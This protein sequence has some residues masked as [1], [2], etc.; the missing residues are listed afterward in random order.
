VGALTP[1][2]APLTEAEQIELH[3]LLQ[4]EAAHRSRRAIDRFFPDTGP[5]RRALYQKHWEDAIDTVHVRHR[6]GGTSVLTFRTCESGREAFQ[7][8]TVHVV[9][10]DEEPTEAIYSE[11]LT[12]TMTCDGVVMCTF[13]P[14]LGM[15]AV[16][17]HF[18][19]STE[20]KA[21]E[22]APYTMF[23][24]WDDVPH[25]SEQSKAELLASYPPHLRQA[26]SKG[27]PHLGSGAIYQVAEDDFVIDPVPLPR[28]CRHAQG[29]E[30]AARTVPVCGMRRSVRSVKSVVFV[31]HPQ[32]HSYTPV[33]FKAGRARAYVRERGLWIEYRDH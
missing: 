12:R 2:N 5:H 20:R 17:V 18:M 16:A 32:T 29:H 25:L 27:I 19:P 22:K 6:S 11:A 13:T 23:I 9:W 31:L 1:R 24:E 3:K 8:A 14:M 7:A 28:W 15:S 21:G 26:R 10:L 4:E 30:P 33:P